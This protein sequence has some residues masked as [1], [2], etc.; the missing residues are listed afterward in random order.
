MNRLRVK[1]DI[2]SSGFGFFILVV[3]AVAAMI[4]KE[5]ILCIAISLFIV[6][7]LLHYIMQL[8]YLITFKENDK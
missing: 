8:L 6:I 4:Y 5:Y 3:C 2:R 1:S 7:S